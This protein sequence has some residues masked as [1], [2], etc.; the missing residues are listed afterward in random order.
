MT[1]ESNARGGSEDGSV[2]ARPVNGSLMSHS[3]P[4]EIK[5]KEN[6]KKQKL[7]TCVSV[8]WMRGLR[9]NFLLTGAAWN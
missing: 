5:G 9:T 8:L 4:Q 1:A 7:L 3:E 6:H 2:N